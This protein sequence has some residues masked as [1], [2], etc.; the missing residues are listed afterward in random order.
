MPT[1]HVHVC[2]QLCGTVQWASCAHGRPTVAPL[3]HLPS[4]RAAL[5]VQRHNTAAAHHAAAEALHVGGQRHV[6]GVQDRTAPAGSRL[7]LQCLSLT[8]LRTKVKGMRGQE[9]TGQ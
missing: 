2:R 4:L 8:A 7:V 3:V 6:L 9:K 5:K 1:A